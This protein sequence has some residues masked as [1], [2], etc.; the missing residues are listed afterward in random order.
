[1]KRTVLGVA[2]MILG[3]V[4]CITGIALCAVSAQ[5]GASVNADIKAM[6]NIQENKVYSG[7]YTALC[8]NGEKITIT[9]SEIIF[10]DGSEESY[11][12]SV[13]KNMPDTNEETGEITYSD[14]CFLKTPN[15][16]F[17]YYP[18]VREIDIDGM[19][20]ALSSI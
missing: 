11:R 13:W 7:T 15:K 16:N 6:V 20:Y 14:Y 18:G 2:V 3:I 1:M 12:L 4:M 5:G 8:G 10:S 9:D 19:I 17:R